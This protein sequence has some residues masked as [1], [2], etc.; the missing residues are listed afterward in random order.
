MATTSIRRLCAL[1]FVALMIAAPAS[2]ATISFAYPASS[3]PLLNPFIG[4]IAWASDTDEHDQPFSLVYA[5]LTW[6]Q[7]EPSRGEYDFEVF[8]ARNQFD[9]WRDAGKHVVLRF[10]MDVPGPKKHMDI[11]EWLY[12]LTGDGTHYR[13]DYGRGYSPN[14]E[15]P[16]LIQAHAAAIR[17]LGARY[18]ADPL[19]AFVELG[20]LGHWGEWHTHEKAGSF[21]L[22]P[23]RAQYVA[24][25]A[26]AFTYAKLMM[27][28]PFTHAA[29]HGAGLFND[30]AAN[31]DAT[32]EWLDWI[33]YGGAFNE[34]GEPE[35]L[36]PMPDAW[37]TAPIGGELATVKDK[38]KLLGD[39]FDDT[40]SLLERSH[41]SWIGPGSFVDIE[42]GGKQ[43][44]N[45][46][47][48]LSRIGYRLRVE[49]LDITETEDA[50]QLTLTWRNDGIAPF[51][52]DWQPTARIVSGDG[53]TSLFPIPMAITDVLP[54]N[55]HMAAL[56]IPKSSLPVGACILEVGIANPA[57]GR[58]AVQLAMIA[59]A[60]DG[61]TE[62][63]RLVLN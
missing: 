32:E 17:A 22:E 30:A 40:L 31:E 16:L 38:K 12:D 1:L 43:Q 33:E 51:Y 29:F 57:D 26:A 7:L 59:P 8:E 55:P 15:N 24:P 3:A 60:N 45:L 18:G 10:V 52:F 21:P 2:A 11:P 47:A 53:S 14:Y 49:R 50:F 25:Y 42:Q 20:S 9:K 41:A 5:D 28:R 27:R 34:T 44:A 46:D 36:V 62:L 39:A 23:V 63:A 37:R 35:A 58:A 48:L 56:L 54:G 61:W 13:T 4:N 19:I 6:A